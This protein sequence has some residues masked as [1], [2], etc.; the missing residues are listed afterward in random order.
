MRQH[1]FNALNESGLIDLPGNERA[2]EAWSAPK[3][4]VRTRLVEVADVYKAA[5]EAQQSPTLAVSK[6]FS[7]SRPAAAKR[8]QRAR[9]AKLIPRPRKRK[10]PR[11]QG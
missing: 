10:P 1:Y 9:D 8:I 5:V 7:L 2:A 6:H 3:E 4:R 11:L